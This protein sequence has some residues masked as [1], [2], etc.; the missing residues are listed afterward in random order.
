[1]A[2]PIDEKIVKMTLD[3]EKFKQE[4]TNTVKSI[5]DVDKSTRSINDIDLSNIAKGIANIES[6]FSA[7]GVVIATVLKRMT[8]AAINAGKKMYQATIGGIVEG[9]KKRALNIEQAKFQFAGLGMDIEQ[10]M[11]DAL[12]A[13]KGTAY[14]LDEAAVAASTLGASGI[15]LGDDMKTA[16]RS[17]SGLAAM[18]NSDY[19][20]MSRI[21]GTV[22]GQGKLMTMQMRQIEARGVNVAAT[23]AKE[24]GTTEQAVREMVTAGKI[25]FETFAT[26]MDN[27]F[28]EQATKA[29]ETYA[30][31]LSN[32]KAALSRVGASV[33]GGTFTKLRD[34][35][36]TTTGVVDGFA[37]SFTPLVDAIL[38]VVDVVGDKLIGAL[39]R[40]DFEKFAELGGVANIVT[41]FNNVV[42]TMGNILGGI[43]GAFKRVFPGSFMDTI[44]K[45]TDR[46]AK[47]S[48]SLKVNKER[49]DT[50]SRIFGG[51]L[52]AFNIV[53]DVAVELAKVFF[54][55]IP[56]DF[57]KGVV[58]FI[59]HL[60]DMVVNFNDSFNAAETFRKVIDTMSDAFQK[61]ADKVK[62]FKIFEKLFDNTKV[63]ESSTMWEKFMNILTKIGEVAKLII[64]PVNE[65]LKSLDMKDALTVGGI[66]GVLILFKKIKD[67]IEA[68]STGIGDMFKGQGFKGLFDGAIEMMGQVTD[69]LTSFTTAVKAKSILAIAI[70]LGLLAGAIYLLGQLEWEHIGKGLAALGLTLGGLVL[71]FQSLNKLDMGG[72]KATKIALTILALSIALSIVA[73]ALKKFKGM[74]MN[75]V[76]QGMFG[77]GMT[78][79]I[80]VTAMNSMNKTLGKAGNLKAGKIASTLIALS[81]AVG[82]LSIAVKSLGKMETEALVKGTV[83]MLAIVGALV[84]GFAIISSLKPPSIKTIFSL[85]AFGI[86][87]QQAAVAFVI[88]A[89]AL[90]LLVPAVQAFSAMSIKELVKGLGAIAVALAV[91]VI[92]LNQT[93]GNV[94]DA[95]SLLI[96]I[97]ALTL[98]VPPMKTFG[99]M[100]LESIGKGLL[101]L[102]GGLGILVLALNLA[103]GTMM[104]AIAIAVAAASLNLLILPMKALG[105]LEWEQI[106]KGLAAIAGVFAV[107]G[108]AGLVLAPIIPVILGLSVALTLIGL[109]MLNIGAGIAVMKAGNAVLIGTKNAT[110][111]IPGIMRGIANEL[112]NIFE[113]MGKGF[114]RMI[115]AIGEG[116]ADIVDSFGRIISAILDLLIEY[117]PKVLDLGVELFLGLLIALERTIPQLIQTTGKLMIALL[118]GLRDYMPQILEIGFEIVIMIITG[119]VM[120]LPTFIEAGVQLIIAFVQGLSKAVKDN[121]PQ[122]IGAFLE[123]LGEIIIV[124]GQALIALLDVLIGGI[125]GVSKKLEK[126]SEGMGEA[127]RE[128]FSGRTLG[129]EMT[130]DISEGIDKGKSKVKESGTKVGK[131]AEEG[132]N[133]MDLGKIGKDK[134]AGLMS[135]LGGFSG[136][137]FDVGALL[138]G[139]TEDGLAGMDLGSIG[140][141]EGEE[142]IKGLTSKK[143]GAEGAA[144]GIAA[145]T[146]QGFSGGSGTSQGARIGNEFNVGLN[147]KASNAFASGKNLANRATSG[148]RSVNGYPSGANFG[149]GFVNGIWGKANAVRDAAVR[150]ANYARGGLNT[151]IQVRSPSR[152]AM[153]SGEFFGE[154]FVLGIRSKAKA[155]LDASR[156]M[157][158]QALSGMDRFID[159]FAEEFVASEDEYEF[160]LKP[161]MDLSGVSTFDDQSFG[162]LANTSTSN[163]DFAKTFRQNGNTNNQKPTS[164][165]TTIHN[166]YELT[167]ET[168]GE[169]PRTT[170]RR[171]AGQFEEAIKDLNDD[172]KR[173][174]GEAVYY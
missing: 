137:S 116:A 156:D 77:I 151:T 82:F 59:A 109:A 15:E 74:D 150:L 136:E 4:V 108:I 40:I 157:A 138:G 98:L 102:A 172:N 54:R 51:L 6:R 87:M 107:M 146:N 162:L 2:R 152:V 96:V 43:S 32:L 168:T 10:A 90:R 13:V 134:G 18:T 66:A 92:A 154:G 30:G 161:V 26:T 11:E 80:L 88:V 164:N 119:L 155:V 100:D 37:D 139:S 63:K 169:L 7:S 28:G 89:G 120:F 83:A 163:L 135:T 27:A 127:V 118:E 85:I 174:I 23:M 133:I 1:M 3:N 86:A 142:F 160:K 144:K 38:V 25:D 45:V 166:I 75:E 79:F 39:K 117:T 78:M 24:M 167:I 130:D 53:K 48:E 171:M 56:K 97:G 140:G 76:V 64:D 20:D 55:L 72:L 9:G 81:I 126:A 148:S 165:P 173:S 41:I 21:F 94:F 143:P 16:L 69:S 14:G 22:A 121:G 58:D 103:S 159:S 129:L 93:K 44:V 123:L 12:Y 106:A 115:V 84:G 19:S 42:E 112:P 131:S 36:N 33:A 105:N 57:L 46:V 67:A 29:N 31:S 132:F 73:S 104:G 95:A 60:A 47:L 145:V 62:G 61:L 114:V 101:V 147:S 124:L 158:D 8:D 122:L 17:I 68:I 170:I 35:I 65:F 5:K 34:V 91:V 110:R 71:A 52:A 111:G 99:G 128:A 149:Q 153:A 141:S 50:L 70:S 49:G 113:S 125:P